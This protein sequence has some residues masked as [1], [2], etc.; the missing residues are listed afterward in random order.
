MPTTSQGLIIMFTP[1]RLVHVFLVA[2]ILACPLAPA[3]AAPPAAPAQESSSSS[4]KDVSELSATKPSVDP[5]TLPGAPVYHKVCAA[6]HEGQVP[7]APH[8]MFLQ[9]MAAQTI[10]EALTTGLMKE[11][12]AA[13]TPAARRQVAEYLAGAPVA[14]PAAHAPPACRGH[15]REFD[16]QQP[17]V[18]LGWG[19]NNDRAI[20]AEVAGLAP[21]DLP[22]LKLRWALEFPGAIRA[23]SQPAIAYGAVYVGSQ[24]GTVYALDLA[25]GCVRWTFRAAAEVR[26]AIVPEPHAATGHER[27]YFADVIAHA[28]ALDARTGRP[29]WSVKVDEHPNAT[30]TGTPSYHD[31]ALYVPVS[32]LEV[33]SAADPK[34]ECCRFRGAVVALDAASGAQRW[35][36]YTISEQPH[37]VRTTSAGTRVLAPSGAPVW[38]SPSVDAARGVLYVGSGEN[39]ASPANDTSDAVIAFRLSD[40]KRLWVQQLTRGDAW[41]VACMMK[42]NPNCPSENGPDVDVAA[43]IIPFKAPAGRELLIV[44]QKN[45]WVYALDPDQVGKIVWQ[46]RV[47]RGGIQGGVHFGMAL[48]GNRLFVPIADLADGHDGRH[49]D[50]APRPGL[51]ALDPVTGAP[52]WSAPAP[53]ACRGRKFCDPGISAALTAVAGVVFAGHMDG[54][55][56]AYDSVSGQVLW[57]YDASE[58]VH[59]VSGVTA[60]GGSFGGPGAAVRDGYLVIN[61]GYGLYFHM[62]G[63]V[64]LVFEKRR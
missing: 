23:R 46:A 1:V 64:L 19:L 13:L 22:G 42:D 44:G 39:Y 38:N 5:E 55:L 52:L 63:N 6:C 41:N 15:A 16:A 32:S 30:V 48:E 24:D 40:G 11:Q 26:T 53:D 14:A 37:A 62:P 8:K 51:Y 57:Q 54:W 27:L 2:G 59:T 60:H 58:P 3:R 34:Y 50:A 20:P 10:L 21:G 61:S 4:L 47:G 31:G 56:R 12:G 28:Y 17:A 29:L 45:G 25:S 7:K 36:A 33:T 18:A 49:Y 35:K 43:S 9:M